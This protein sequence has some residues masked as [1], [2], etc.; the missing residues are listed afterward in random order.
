MEYSRCE[1]HENGEPLD[2]ADSPALLLAVL[3]EIE[4]ELIE[5]GDAVDT[6]LAAAVAMVERT[7]PGACLVEVRKL[8]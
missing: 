8:R 7:F 6:E 1:R 3:R 2:E 4:R 5:L